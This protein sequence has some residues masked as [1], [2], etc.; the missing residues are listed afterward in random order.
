MPHDTKRASLD[1]FMVFFNCH[2]HSEKTA[3]SDN[4]PPTQD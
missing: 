4:G 2:I 3:E 1:Q